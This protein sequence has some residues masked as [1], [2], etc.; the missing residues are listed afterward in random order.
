MLPAGQVW[1]IMPSVIPRTSTLS[2]F[3]K[4]LRS[5]TQNGNFSIEKCTC[6]DVEVIIMNLIL[7]KLREKVYQQVLIGASLLLWI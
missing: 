5:R 1:D 4:R 6:G 7:S 3:I 2:D